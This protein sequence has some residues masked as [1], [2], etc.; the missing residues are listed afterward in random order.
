VPGSPF[1]DNYPTSFPSATPV[2]VTVTPNNQVYVLN[3]LENDMVA[4]NLN[5]SIGA[6]TLIGRTVPPYGTFTF[7]GN[8]IR[9]DPAG[10]FLYALGFDASNP[11]NVRLAITGYGINSSTGTLTEVPHAPYPNM[12]A[13][14]SF[15]TD[16]VA[17]T[18]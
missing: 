10:R 16:A 13:A 14:T 2:S 17:V 1:V 4:Y 3:E 5:S 18:P 11:Q 15:A 9:S 8:S 7:I 12:G 6:L